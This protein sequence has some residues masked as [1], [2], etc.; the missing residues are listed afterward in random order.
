MLL[1]GKIGF[2]DTLVCD[3]GSDGELVFKCE[4]INMAVI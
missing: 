4:K 3:V 2:G 1:S